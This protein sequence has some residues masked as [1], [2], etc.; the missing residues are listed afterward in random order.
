M[1]GN[2]V[3]TGDDADWA[4]CHRVGAHL[5]QRHQH[6]AAVHAHEGYETSG[7]KSWCGGPLKPRSC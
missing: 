6:A 5:A 1:A 7:K 2:I 3:Q 4:G